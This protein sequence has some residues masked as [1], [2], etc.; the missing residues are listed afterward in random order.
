LRKDY[1]KALRRFKQVLTYWPDKAETYYNVACMY[2]RLNR[3]DESI[4][5]LN[6]AVDKGYTNWE[7]MKT[8]SDLD[9][10]RESSA[11]KKLI[12]GHL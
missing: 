8:D 6:K 9:N 1:S 4:E 2:S 12:Q 3:I 7:S 10:I 11:Y 5:W